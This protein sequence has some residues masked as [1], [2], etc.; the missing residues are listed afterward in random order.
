MKLTLFLATILLITINTG[1]RKDQLPSPNT[2]PPTPIDTTKFNY[3]FLGHTYE[4]ENTIDP[5]LMPF[6]D[7]SVY[8]Q[9]WL[10]GDMCSETTKD[11]A[12]LDY[13]DNLF[14]LGSPNTHWTL[15]NHDIRNGNINWIT[16]KT[17]RPTFY[18]TSFNGICLLV[19]NT[20]FMHSGTDTASINAQYDLIKNVCDTI[21][22]ASHLILLTHGLPWGGVGGAVDSCTYAANAN[23][24]FLKFRF[25][26]TQ[27][28][29][30]GIYPLLQQVKNK[31][32]E[33]INIGGDMGQNETEFEA[34]SADGIHFIG[35]GITA[36]T[37]WNQQFPTAGE[38]DKILILEHEP[39]TKTITWKFVPI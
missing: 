10:G 18:T 32:I 39:A 17:Q 6:I 34:V 26:P 9:F 2:N 27:W 13:L 22:D 36:E 33:V 19:L 5:R 31:D 30:D 38:V 3:L 16:D 24:S 20:S 37:G 23:F 25:N 7:T 21:Q 8:D 1:C 11:Q 28:F 15:G 29:H 12:T 35:S 4:G 14:D